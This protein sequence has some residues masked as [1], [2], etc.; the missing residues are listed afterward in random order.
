[1][2]YDVILLDIDGTLF[3]FLASSRE[4]LEQT[5]ARF[6]LPFSDGDRE[7]FFTINNGF[8]AAYERGEIEKAAIYEGRFY[9]FFE[10]RGEAP[11]VPTINRYY[12]ARLGQSCHVIPHARE[13][14]EGL[15]ARGCE[16]HAVTNGESL[17]QLPRIAASGLGHLLP[18]VFV[19][20][21]VGAQKPTREFFDF[22]FRAIGEEKRSRAIVL[23]DS[24]TSDMQG[25][26][27]AGVAT[28]L[29]GD[30]QKADDRCD[31]VVSDLLDFLDVIA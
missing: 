1:M 13:L 15:T 4:C 2:R 19:S 7:R 9:R 21:D 31:F 8:W 22:V 18:S 3:D 30:R 27:N 26:R 23:G 25:G 12:M 17:T 14:L 24:L 29:F 5:F 16:I 28:C 10:E 11:D 20:D 6:G